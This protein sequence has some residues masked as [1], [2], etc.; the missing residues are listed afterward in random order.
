MHFT[1]RFG[2]CVLI[3]SFDM[4]IVRG[5]KLCPDAV[6][7]LV[8]IKVSKMCHLGLESVIVQLSAR[9]IVLG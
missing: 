6:N 8:M 7:S 9:H 3:Q 4:L 5:W 1:D 2:I